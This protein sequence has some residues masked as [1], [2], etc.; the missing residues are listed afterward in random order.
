MQGLRWGPADTGEH[1]VEAQEVDQVKG[2]DHDQA[3]NGDHFKL[4]AGTVSDP[5]RSPHPDEGDQQ[6]DHLRHFQQRPVGVG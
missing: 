3:A 6:C 4:A 1:A 2:Q 5:P